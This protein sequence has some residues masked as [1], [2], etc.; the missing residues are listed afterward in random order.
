ME[1]TKFTPP[2][3]VKDE[4]VK[5]E[6]I[7]PEQEKL[8]DTKIDIVNQEGIKDEGIAVPVIDQGKQIIE[9][10]KPE[11]ENK[12]FEKVEI[13]ASF[14]GGERAWANYLRKNLDPN[15]PVDNGAPAG[16][17]TVTVQFIV[18]K[19]GNISDVRSLS[20]HGFGMEDEAVKIIKKGPAWEPA[21]QNGRKVN[22]Y[23]RQPITFVVEEQ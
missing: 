11:D 12:V 1:M 3:I 7:P 13:E 4:E 17:Y 10:K 6:D 19:Q 14:P 15:V 8:E 22:A 23:R 2:K 9:E 5:K 20:K 21:V 16:T 18:D